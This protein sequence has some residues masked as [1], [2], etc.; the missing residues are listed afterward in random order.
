SGKDYIVVADE[1]SV[2]FLDR[3]GNVRLKTTE[4]VI[5]A[6]GSEMRLDRGVETSL[7]FSAP[8]GT[9]QFVSFDGKVRKITLNTFNFDHTFDFFDIDGDGY[10]EFIFIDKSK[11]YLYD[12]DYTEL[13]VRDFGHENLIGPINFTFSSV[14]RKI[15]IYN[16]ITKQI[17]LVD[18][19]GNDMKGFPVRGYSKFS[20]GK[21]SDK[22]GLHLIVGGNDN[23]LYNYKL[24]IEGNN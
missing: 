19:R 2:Y 23:F 1:N 4:P 21:L 8:D 9:V 6:R 12:H 17:F 7:V 24:N 15:G 13:F 10:G 11:L 22:G 3:T 16:T 18:K 5:C 14:D 20:I